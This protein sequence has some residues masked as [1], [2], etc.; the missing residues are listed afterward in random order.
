MKDVIVLHLSDIHFGEV[1]KFPENRYSMKI[2]THRLDYYF[3]QVTDIVNNMIEQPEICH[4]FLTGDIVHN[5]TMRGSAKM[6]TETNIREQVSLVA[7]VLFNRIMEFYRKTETINQILIHGIRGNHG[8][9][10]KYGEEHDDSNFDNMVYD[11]LNIM[12]QN[13]TENITVKTVGGLSAHVNINKWWFFAEHLDTVRAS[14]GTPYYGLNR[15]K[16]RRYKQLAGK[17]DYYLCGHFHR[18]YEE[19]DGVIRTI[20]CPSLVGLD[21]FAIKSGGGNLAAQNM[22]VINHK[23]GMVVNRLIDVGHIQR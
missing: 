10:G 13:V 8:R 23:H 4:I 18:Y 16:D 1:V 21:H 9:V 7:E 12:F 3:T 11:L 19:H 14:L 6:H 2:A 20:M 5:E 15:Q 17:L 22:Y